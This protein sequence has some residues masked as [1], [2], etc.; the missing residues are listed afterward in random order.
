MAAKTLAEM[1]T[2]TST[3]LQDTGETRWGDAE[4]TLHL[5]SALRVAAEYWPNVI[6]EIVY[7]VYKTGS[8]TSTSTDHL[9]D[10]TK[11]QFVDADIGRTVINITDGT[12]ATITACNSTSDVTIDTNILVSGESYEIFCTGGSDSRDVYIGGISDLIDVEYLEYKIGKD[13][14]ELRNFS[15]LASTLRMTLDDQLATSENALPVFVFCNK[16]HTV[17]ASASTLTPQLER[18]V[19]E[20]TAAYASIAKG[21]ESVA[22][23]KTAISAYNKIGAAILEMNA[24]LL[25]AKT[26]LDSGRTEAGKVP[27]I[28]TLAETAIGKI[29]GQLTQ[30]INDTNAGRPRVNNIPKGGPIASTYIPLAAASLSTASAFIEKASIDLRQAAADE[31]IANTYASL[32]SGELSQAAALLNQAY[33][34]IREV[35]GRLQMANTVRLYQDWGESKLALVMADLRRIKKPK[36]KHTYARD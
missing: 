14:R 11:A 24:G 7:T 23:V 22:Q 29:Q 6:R 3:V 9:V 5:A 12:I 10:A 4:L 20:L 2:W 26:D 34:Y 27:A 19:V 32:A 21:Q 25:R 31:S 1:K 8:A 16:P 13:P 35:D 36:T 15:R 17:T 18:L 28:V 33:G 30:A